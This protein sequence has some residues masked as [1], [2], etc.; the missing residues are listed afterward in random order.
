M[1]AGLDRRTLLASATGLIA[2]PLFAADLTPAT[3]VILLG[4]KGGPLPSPTRAAP[5]TL[6]M[7]GGKAFVVDCGNGV[8]L[9][10]VK[11]GIPLSSLA[12]VFI[13]HNHSDHVIDVATLLVLAWEAGL[14]TPV[15]VHGPPPLKHIVASG[16]EVSAYDIEAR[17]REEG[18]PPLKPLVQVEEIARPGV[19]LRTSEVTVTTALVDHLS[20][21]PA[22]AYRFDTRDRSIVISGDTAPNDALIALARDA[23]VLIHEALYAPMLD[24]IKDGNA[25]TLRDHLVRSHT[26]TEA[27]G[28]IAAKARVR[29]LVLSHLVPGAGVTDE[30]WIA[31]VRKHYSGPVVV[32]RDLL[33]V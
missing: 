11:A 5:S 17:I 16:L 33:E 10:I 24:S 30:Q 15:T 7:V 1:S 18:R 26:T 23:D 12:Q 13:T 19:V 25:P 4:T 32:G 29:K 20:V 9:Q 2:A 22:L 21:R 31:G 6:L 27:L 14:Q 8:A 3:R 28:E